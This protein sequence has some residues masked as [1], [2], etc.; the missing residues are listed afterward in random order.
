M[1]PVI[2]SVE[3]QREKLNLSQVQTTTA[4]PVPAATIENKPLQSTQAAKIKIA[5][6]VTAFLQDMGRDD[7]SDRELRQLLSKLLSP[8]GR[9]NPSSTT[10]RDYSSSDFFSDGSS[11]PWRHS[12]DES[13]NKTGS[14]ISSR[15]VGTGPTL[16][17]LSN[18]T[19]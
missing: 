10:G 3:S 9:R 14:V 16:P 8:T 1:P 18:V 4:Q 12:G 5:K 15:V 17:P 7:L 19:V 13:V 6:L 11:E 2:D